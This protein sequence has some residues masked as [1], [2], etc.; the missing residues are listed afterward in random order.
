VGVKC[1]RGWKK[2]KKEN[3]EKVEPRKEVKKREENVNKTKT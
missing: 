3:K 1:G 2:K